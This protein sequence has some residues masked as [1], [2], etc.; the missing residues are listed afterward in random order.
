MTDTAQPI[1]LNDIPCEQRYGVPVSAMGEEGLDTIAAFTADPRR[2]LAAALGEYRHQV[3]HPPTFVTGFE[4]KWVQVFDTCGCLNH[5][6]DLDY[7]HS[8]C[9]CPHQ[10]LPP[11]RPDTWIWVMEDT[12]PDAPNAVPVH[13][14]EMGD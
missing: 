13:E 14:F 8:G 9:D 1:P 4:L 12:T 6:P 3:G 10:G 7:L 2:A 5:L 11:C